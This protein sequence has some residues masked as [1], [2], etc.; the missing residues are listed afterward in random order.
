MNIVL[1]AFLYL[2]VRSKK[3]KRRSYEKFE[4]LTL[5]KLTAGFNVINICFCGHDEKYFLVHSVF[6]LNYTVQ[7][8]VH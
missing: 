3:T 2:H 1:A 7:R 5:M 4:R 8:F 6:A